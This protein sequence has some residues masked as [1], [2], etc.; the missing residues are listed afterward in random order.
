MRS[1]DINSDSDTVRNPYEFLLLPSLQSDSMAARRAQGL[2]KFDK[3]RRLW[4]TFGALG[5]VAGLIPTI[6]QGFSSR[7]GFTFSLLPILA[8][9]GAMLQIEILR[10]RERASASLQQSG[11]FSIA[12]GPVRSAEPGAE[13]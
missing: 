13:A 7:Y 1:A 8:E 3:I 6:A 2:S 4:R 12:P 10:R 5:F 9:L 11:R